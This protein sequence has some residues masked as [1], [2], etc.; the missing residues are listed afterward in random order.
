MMK[1]EKEQFGK[2]IREKRKERGYSSTYKLAEDLHVDQ[3][4]VYRIET[5]ERLPSF[6]LFFDLA[7]KLQVPPS[8]LV[9]QMHLPA[10]VKMVSPDQDH[11]SAGSEQSQ[12]EVEG[13]LLVTLPS[14]LTTEDLEVIEAIAKVLSD[15][16]VREKKL[17]IKEQLEQEAMNENF[18]EDL[19]RAAANQRQKEITSNER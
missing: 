6:E 5:G 13:N 14:S 15:R 3:S 1:I 9:M 7:T 4:T 8:E 18:F 19:E 17:A 16:R 2:F 10:L 12:R 11:P